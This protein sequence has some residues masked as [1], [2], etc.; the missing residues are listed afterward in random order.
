MNKS[1]VNNQLF[2]LFLAQFKEIIREPAVL[3]W[4]IIFPILMSLGLGVAF[5]NKSDVIH[6]LAIVGPVPHV[7]DSLLVEHGE[8]RSKGIETIE[9][10]IMPNSKI[11]NSIFVFHQMS[12][13]D[14]MVQLKRGQINVIIQ[15]NKI[16]FRSFEP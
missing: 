14:A 2:L 13:K 3:F 10:I 8:R 16:Q 1:F 9:K 12:W 4:G 15:Q 11:G 6:N 7:L 5:T